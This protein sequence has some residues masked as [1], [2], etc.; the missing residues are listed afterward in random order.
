MSIMLD[1]IFSKVAENRA[2]G[3]KTIIYVDEF[4]IMMKHE[5]S[6]KYIDDM[7]R[8]FRKY[9]A[10]VTGITQNLQDLMNREEGRSIVNNATISVMLGQQ[11]NEVQLLKEAYKLSSTQ[12]LYIHEAPPGH[13]LLK[14]GDA[15]IPFENEF[16]KSLSLYRAMTTNQM[17]LREFQ[18]N[19]T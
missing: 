19:G 15:Y 1:G 6:A 16:D 2:A 8:R 4:W 5:Q 3:R 18:K 13:G 12:C 10:W 7:W 14:F 17:E 11:A 9:G